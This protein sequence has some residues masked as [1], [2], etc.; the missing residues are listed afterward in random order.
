[1][2]RIEKRPHNRVNTV[3]VWTAILLV[4]LLV[5]YYI[6]TIVNSNVTSSQLDM[7][8]EH[9]YPVTVQAGSVETDVVRMI[10]EAERLLYIHTPE[11]VAKV[12]QNINGMLPNLEK[13]VGQIDDKFLTDPP[14]AQRLKA[15]Y[16]QLKESQAGLIAMAYDQSKTTGDIA[17][18]ESRYI[19]PQ[20]EEMRY[21]TGVIIQKASQTFEKLNATA[22]WSHKAAVVWAS[23]LMAAVLA[24]LLIYQLLLKGKNKEIV[25]RNQLFDLLSQNVDHVFVIESRENRKFEFVSGNAERILGIRPEE[26]MAD[27]NLLFRRLERS[28]TEKLR[29]AG[30][31]NDGKEIWTEG[32]RYVHP[33]TG[34]PRDLRL[35]V[36][37]VL[38]SKNVSQTILA[39]TDE[40]DDVRMQ[41]KLEDALDSA[42][43]ANMAKSQFLSN[44]S[45]DIRTPMNAIVG[46]T[47]IAAANLQD[48]AKVKGC[49]EKITVSSRH[50]LSLINDVL[51]MSRIESGKIVLSE[52]DFGLSDMLHNLVT[53][54]QP[55]AKAQ[56]LELEVS[57]K[58]IRHEAV[59]GDMLRINQLLLNIIGNAVK[60]TPAGGR[61]SLEISERKSRY[62]SYGTYEF[63]VSDTGVGMTPAFMER[64]FEPFERASDSTTSRI[65]GTGLG[66][67]ITKSIV[68]MMNGDIK[69]E[70]REGE[71]SRFAVTLYL[72]LQDREEQDFSIPALQSLRALVVDDDRDVCENTAQILNEIGMQS[73]W[74]L[75]GREAVDRAAEA[76]RAAED[77]HTIIID[78]KMPE[79]DGLETTR[80][81]RRQVGREVPIIILTAYD[82]GEIEEEAKAAGVSAFVAKPLLKS[83]LYHVLRDLEQESGLISEADEAVELHGKHILLAEDNALNAEIAEEFIRMTGAA[84]DWVTD[85]KAAVDRMAAAEEGAY[86]LIFMDIQMPNMDGYQA[87]RAIR[88]LARRDVKDI[89][90]VAMTANAFTEDVRRAK[91]AGMNEH[92]AKPLDI[93][94]LSLVMKN[95]LL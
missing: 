59:V 49:L 23:V 56:Q 51:D 17:A 82:W 79:M 90:I 43:S 58:N 85:G 18:Y 89:P 53:I 39:L 19:M 20:L 4:A 3:S 61:V 80:Q 87:T 31:A 54:V 1:M 41:K 63:V 67:A 45:H 40:T 50:L 10:G 78:W 73:E 72:K 8:R 29:N 38:D 44:M 11:A 48:R 71:G 12:E 76:H 27:N 84:V 36:Y 13:S 92:I 7:I 9:P 66:M 28:E 47:A 6:V 24:A 46:M 30:R 81:I 75:S 68:D 52:E 94:Q 55:Q 32:F 77:Y 2:N 95:W 70:S 34:E 93:K 21:L 26:W 16:Y 83:R 35:T 64:I 91:E 86:D 69:V 57:I 62:H 5:L 22:Q 25:Y 37:S 42:R 65:E 14:S 60:F 33:R 15:L 74:V 88:A